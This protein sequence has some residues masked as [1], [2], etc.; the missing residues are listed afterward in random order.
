M[1]FYIF[2]AIR[3]PEGEC[4]FW[5]V[6]WHDSALCYGNPFCLFQRFFDAS[7]TSERFLLKINS[8][9][10][11]VS[12]A[13]IFNYKFFINALL[14]IILEPSKDIHLLHRERVYQKA[15]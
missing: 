14:N 5:T 1:G 7:G 3:W 4:P 10:L 15:E 13:P 2:N 9:K 8:I 6:D 11:V 12:R